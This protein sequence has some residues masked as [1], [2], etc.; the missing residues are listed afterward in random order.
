MY[1]SGLLLKAA[2]LEFLAGSEKRNILC[3]NVVKD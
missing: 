1:R 2:K 3:H